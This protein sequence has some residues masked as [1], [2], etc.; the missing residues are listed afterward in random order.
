VC[1]STEHA[2]NPANLALLT[3]NHGHPFQVGPIEPVIDQL[4][5]VGM[6][7]QDGSADQAF[8]CGEVLQPGEPQQDVLLVR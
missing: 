1:R 3:I 2:D 8:Y 4:R 7:H 6:I 5:E